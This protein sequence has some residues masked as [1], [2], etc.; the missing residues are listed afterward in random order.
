MAKRRIKKRPIQL[1]QISR[2]ISEKFLGQLNRHRLKLYLGSV[3]VLV[4]WLLLNL[5]TPLISLWLPLTVLE[6]SQIKAR[7]QLNNPRAHLELAEELLRNQNLIAAQKEL[8]LARALID[9]ESGSVELNSVEKKVYQIDALAKEVIRWEKISRDYPNFRDGHLQ[10]AYYYYQLNRLE[11][12]KENLA[13]AL[14]LDPNFEP[15]RELE[16][17]IN[18]TGR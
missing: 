3:L 5:F 6:K 14:N 13:I 11:K 12:A 8:E 9:N 16:K 1:P 10:L 7:N 15:S 2:I 18:E 17:I 4:F